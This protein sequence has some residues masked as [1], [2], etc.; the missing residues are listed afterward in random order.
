MKSQGEGQTLGRLDI[1]VAT[2]KEAL[3][4]FLDAMEQET[5]SDNLM[6]LAMANFPT[7]TD[8]SAPLLERILEL[9]PRNLEALTMLGTV[10]WL[11]ANDIKAYD[12]M[13]RAKE[14]APD[15]CSVLMHEA[16]LSQDWDEALS[17]YRRVID[18]YPDSRDAQ[19]ARENLQRMLAVTDDEKKRSWLAWP[20][21][22]HPPDKPCR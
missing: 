12:C 3:T 8:V 11:L 2:Y 7:P 1:A 22:Q 5:H 18:L 10:S 6:R 13:K 9:E 15:D 16:A 4:E 14:I 19:A 21:G 20:P 17:L